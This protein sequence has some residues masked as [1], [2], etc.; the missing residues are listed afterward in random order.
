MFLPPALLL[1]LFLSQ[2]KKQEL[3]NLSLMFG[4]GILGSIYFWLPALLDSQLMRYDTLFNFADHYPVLRQLITPY[5]GYGGSHSGPDDGVSFFLGI[6]NLLV[7]VGG[8]GII[9]MFYQKLSR[10]KLIIIG[11]SL[12]VFVGSVFM[13]NFR[14]VPLWIYLPMLDYFQF[15]WRFLMMTTVSVPMMLMLLDRFKLGRWVAGLI[16]I[17]AV[18]TTNSYFKPEHFLGRNDEYYLKRYIPIPVAQSEYYEIQEEY[19]RLPKATQIRPDK[20]YPVVNLSDPRATQISQ[21]NGM[22]L[23]AIINS[24]NGTKLQFNKYYFPGWRAWVNNQEVEIKSG[25]PFNQMVINIPK[26]QSLVDIKFT[27]VGHKIILDVVSLLTIIG[28]ILILFKRKFSYG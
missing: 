26:G 13:M 20:N 19:L 18:L 4:I 3:L 7:L 9:G 23:S 11:W 10:L 27:E 25:E 12:L 1:G 5:W 21:Y 17:L 22:N 28:S 15:P 16:I 14:S 8:V 6:T 2:G 24:E